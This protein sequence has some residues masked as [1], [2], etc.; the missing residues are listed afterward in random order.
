MGAF[1]GTAC[2]TL[3]TVSK[4]CAQ[5]AL[6]LG[7][8][9]EIADAADLT[10]IPAATGH[11]VS[12]DIVMDSTKQ[13]YQWRIGETEAEFNAQSI[14]QKG[15]QTFQN[16]LTVFLPLSRAEVSNMV[17]SIINGDFVILFRDKNGAVRLLGTDASPAK[18]PDGGIQEV[19]SPDRNGHTVTFENIGHTPYFYTGAV[20][21]LLSPAA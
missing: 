15:N 18:I 17:N 4:I 7:N 19:V 12:D 10:S 16:T 1:D 2:G 13:F 3:N 11:T 14:G 5:H 8:T 20:T 21:A 6:G 9:I